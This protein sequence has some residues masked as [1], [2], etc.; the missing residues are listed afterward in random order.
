MA[1]RC[2]SARAA[3]PQA[4]PLG[5]SPGTAPR[6][7]LYHGPL[8]RDISGH[9]TTSTG[10]S[11]MRL[12]HLILIPA[13]LTVIA[14]APV[15][16]QHAGH[17][18][19]ATERGQ[20]RLPAGWELRLDRAD[21]NAAEI[22]FMDMAPGWHV[23]TG[24]SAIVYRPAQTASGRFRVESE[25]HLFDP[26]QRR[27]GYGIFIGGRDLQGEAQAY[28]YFLIRR[29]GQFIVKTRRG[30]EAPTEIAWTE[31][32]AI[33]P[34]ADGA[35]SVAN[36]LAIDVGAEHVRFLVNGEQVATLPRGTLPLD[37]IVGI[38]ANH[39]VNAHVSR[40]DIHQH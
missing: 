31:H 30:A 25:I 6:T 35:Q 4:H 28:T 21:Q 14:A 26:G 8:Q 23:T 40:L 22:S 39:S 27:E 18:A 32:T 36:T 19:P 3:V 2:E 34:W 16:A 24:P 5:R 13:V 38:R 1:G 37:G 33:R 12:E 10:A 11:T 15:A 9:S 29:D 17:G 7:A 20:A